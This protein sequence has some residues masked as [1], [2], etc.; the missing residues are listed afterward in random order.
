MTDFRF[1]Y[2]KLYHTI[3]SFLVIMCIAESPNK[4]TCI[5]YMEEYSNKY[6][7]YYP[8]HF[9]NFTKLLQ[10]ENILLGNTLGNTFNILQNYLNIINDKIIN[11]ILYDNFTYIQVIPKINK[12]KVDIIKINANFKEAIELLIMKIIFLI[13]GILM[14]NFLMFKYRFVKFF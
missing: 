7:S 13:I 9:L 2:R 5:N 14:L 4:T 6:N 1:F 12:K 8:G 10:E 3:A 11:N